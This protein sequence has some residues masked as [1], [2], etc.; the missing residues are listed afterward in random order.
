M[1]RKQWGLLTLSL[2]L[3]TIGGIIG[4]VV[5]IDPFEI[6]HQATAFIPP[7]VDMEL[8]K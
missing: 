3:L 4:T 7:I 5:L 6:Y 1:T 2:L 8:E